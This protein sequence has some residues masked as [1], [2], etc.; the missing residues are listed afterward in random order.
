MPPA[1]PCRQPCP[2]PPPPSPFSFF[3][4]HFVTFSLAMNQT[5]AVLSNGRAR[6]NLP[7]DTDRVVPLPLELCHQLALLDRQVAHQ[8]VQLR[9]LLRHHL[10]LHVSSQDLLEEELDGGVVEPV[11]LR[12]RSHDERR[13]LGSHVTDRDCR[14]RPGNLRQ[15]CRPSPGGGGFS[16]AAYTSRTS[17]SI[18]LAVVGPRAALC[19]SGHPLLGALWWV[20]AASAAAT[21]RCSCRHHERSRRCLRRIATPPAEIRLLASITESPQKTGETLSADRWWWWWY[22]RCYMTCV[23]LH[24]RQ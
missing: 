4:F 7:C 15:K 5:T 22:R 10:I 1:L 2:S 14:L 18:A 24:T 20:A 19:C 6:P 3:S 9:L 8:L 21:L 12:H 17:S 11:V 23:S 13:G 16:R